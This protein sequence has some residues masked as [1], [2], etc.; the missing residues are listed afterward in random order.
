M[1]NDGK[2]DTGL[3]RIGTMKRNPEA[4]RHGSCWMLGCETLDRD[5]A[6]FRKYKDYIPALGIPLVRLQAGWAKTEKTKGAYDFAWLDSIVNDAMELG[7]KCLLETDYGNPVYEGGG[8]WDLAGGFPTSEE[9]L[10]A[11]DAWV[12]KLV[13][14][15][16]D[17]VNE[18]AMWNEPDIA[19]DN[20][21]DSIVDFNIR[22][23]R[24][25]RSLAPKSRIAGLSLAHSDT[26]YFEKCIRKLKEQEALGL[27]DSFIYHGYKYNPDEAADF[28]PKLQAILGKFGAHAV[29]R[30]GENG[31]PSEETQRFALSGYPWTEFS[32]AKWDL[33]RFIGDFCLGVPSSIFT[34]CDFNHI[35]RQINRKGLL[36]ADEKHNV[37]RPKLAY[38]A[39]QN[40]TTL[41]NDLLE[42]VPGAASIRYEN[43]C[44]IYAFAVQGRK[45]LVFWDRSSIPTNGTYTGRADILMRDFALKD[46]VLIDVLS[47]TVHEIPQ[48]CIREL[49]EITL[50]LGMPCGD[51]PFVIAE[52]GLV[53]IG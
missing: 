6:D 41:F 35:G 32:Q 18:W 42:P 22:T 25:I 23:A 16:R 29:I 36:L 40:M 12:E 8:G 21:P 50:C 20:T 37:L 7:L 39:I 5:F 19:K 24:I 15:F 30:Q 17:R 11:W 13:L 26:A 44:Q 27:F 52:K 9:A 3:A 49:G 28:G 38:G 4:A 31:C 48:A 43:R 51:T 53:D 46:P 47:G 10:A 14:H 1:A 33:R 45:M 34:I 2:M